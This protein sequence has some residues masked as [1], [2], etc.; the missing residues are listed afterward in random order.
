MVSRFFGFR[1]PTTMHAL[2]LH[3]VLRMKIIPGTGEGVKLIDPPKLRLV[4]CTVLP[5]PPKPSP[6]TCDT[7]AGSTI[8]EKSGSDG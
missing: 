3:D 6:R 7:P 4:F 5:P 2:M 1:K 8:G